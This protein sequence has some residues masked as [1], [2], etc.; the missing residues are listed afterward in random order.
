MINI[1]VSE[2]KRVVIV[3][4][5]FAGL[6]LAMKLRHSG[7]QVVIVDKHNYHQFQPLFYQVATAGLEPSAISFPLRKIFHHYKDYHIR[8]AEVQNI[9]THKQ[10]LWTTLGI[11]QYDYLVLT[12]GVSNFFFGMKTMESLSKPMKSVSEALDLRNTLLQ[13]FENSLAAATDEDQEGFL[14]VVVVGGG[15][16]GI[17]ISGAL[18]DMRKYVLGK[19]YPEIKKEKIH[20]YLFEGMNRLLLALSERS[21]EKAKEFLERLGVAVILNTQVRNYDGKN[22]ETSDGNRIRTN[23]VIWTAGITGARIGGLRESS[24]GRKNRILVDRFSKVTG[25][26]NIFA[27]GDVALMEEP[28]F[29]D[30]HP[31]VAPVAIQQAKLLAKNLV[32][33]RFQKDLMP[34]SYKDK[35]TMATVGR[36]L[37]IVEL[38]NAR[39]YGT[40]AWM[41]WMFIHL[42]SIVGI[43]N[44]FLILINWFW[45]YVTYDTSLRLILKPKGC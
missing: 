34:F 18:A 29:P 33:M 2:K 8:I 1:P 9:D 14:N 39:F 40:F 32:R 21:G 22:I 16:T 20:I 45:N 23:L 37:A 15:P 10:Q 3:G 27:L 24:Y 6:K 4:C 44:R 17:E 7:Y 38:P 43:R 25:Y 36:N 26:S 35:G 30:G 5:G 31:Q 28:R 12:Q 19:D 41:V 11:I 13:N 42:M